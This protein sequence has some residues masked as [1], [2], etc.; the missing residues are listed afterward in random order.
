MLIGVTGDYM[1]VISSGREG[2][3]PG[4]GLR[5]ASRE[6][7]ELRET[8]PGGPTVETIAGYIRRWGATTFA[9]LPDGAEATIRAEAD[10]RFGAAL[11]E[12]EHSDEPVPPIRAHPIEVRFGNTTTKLDIVSLTIRREDGTY[13]GSAMI[14]KPGVSGAVLG[15]LALG[16]AR[17][18]ER[19]MDLI[20]PAR[21]PG[22]VLFAD[23]E[24]STSLSRRLSSSD[25]FS[26]VRR[27][28]YLGDDV[29]VDLGGIV[30]KHVGDGF[31]AFF[32]AGAD[33]SE[34][35]AARSAI[36]A[37]RRLR[38]VAA[39]VAE[40]SGLDREQ[41]TLRF[42]LHWGASLFVGRLITSGRIEATALG[43]EVNEA[44]RIEACAAGGLALASKPLIERLGDE[45]AEQ[46]GLAPGGAKYV[47]LGELASATE[48][49]LRD[50]PTISVCAV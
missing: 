40:H 23:L 50:A 21:R 18:F 37:A 25:Y 35:T 8:W 13:A 48:K 33:V 43:D 4:L 38:K 44:A 49:A 39:G 46:L 1:R 6:Q 31:T 36:E 7:T 24:G 22:A 20:Q 9:E 29:V 17:L 45:D 30:G 19:M 27:L 10:P 14:S 32:L 47:P 12:T 42:G 2:V 34:S 3:D 26:L 15:M 5:F 28:S 16:D 11:D 41:V